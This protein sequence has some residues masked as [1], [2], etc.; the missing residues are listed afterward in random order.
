MGK[1][2]LVDAAAVGQA[3][4]T[5]LLL[6]QSEWWEQEDDGLPL[7]QNILGTRGHPNNLQAVDLLMQERILSTPNV[8]RIS[9]FHSS[10]ENRAY[11]FSCNVETAFGVSIPI[12][13][14]F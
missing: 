14:T 2:F 8:A 13:M 4:K 9:E 10:Y 7:F 12:S 5:R 3:I 1:P 11:S 6:L